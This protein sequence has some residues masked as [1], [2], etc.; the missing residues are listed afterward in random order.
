MK[1][2]T[3]IWGLCSRLGLKPSSGG[4]YAAPFQPFVAPTL[5]RGAA[6]VAAVSATC[7]ARPAPQNKFAINLKYF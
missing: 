5:Q 6:V 7:A 4:D 1:C 2:C 3:G